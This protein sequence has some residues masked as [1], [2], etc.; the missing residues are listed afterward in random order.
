MVEYHTGFADIN[1]HIFFLV[2]LEN[3]L[4]LSCWDYR[5]VEGHIPSLQQIC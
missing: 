1:A 3:K 4:C 2:L 5:C